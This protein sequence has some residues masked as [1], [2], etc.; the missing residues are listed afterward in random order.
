MVRN[1]IKTNLNQL[2]EGSILEKEQD[3]HKVNMNIKNNNVLS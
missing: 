1:I 3:A 2:I